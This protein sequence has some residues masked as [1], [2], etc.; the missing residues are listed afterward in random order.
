MKKIIGKAASSGIS[1]AKA[2]VIENQNFKIDRK[3]V[4]DSKQ[5]IMIFN[6]AIKEAEKQIS[7][8]RKQ[9]IEKLGEKKAAIFDAHLAILK[10][11]E[12]EKQVKDLINNE[13]V[14]ASFAV[15]EIGNN[16][17]TIFLSMEDQYMK[18]RA[19]DVEDVT[20]RVIRIIEKIEI[21]DLSLINEPVIIISNDLTPSET[22]QLN[23]KF[24]KGFVIAIG[25]RT[26]HSAI[27]ARSLEIP[28]IVGAGNEIF[29][30]KSRDEVLIDG[31]TGE[32]YVSP[33]Q[34]VKKEFQLKK[35][36]YKHIF[37]SE[38]KF[39]DKET[40]TKDGWKSVVAANIGL[41]DDIY[42]IKKFGAQGVGLFRT[43]FLY[44][45]SQDWPTEEE[46]FEIYKKVLKSSK[47]KIV[48]R[49]LDIGGDKKLPY[50]TFPKE[51]N[52]FLGHRA[53][54]FQLS[55]P[56]VL[57]AQF[58]ALLRASKYGKLAINIPMISTIGEF[59]KVKKNFDHIKNILESEGHK[60]GKYEL[61]IMV[62]VPAT[63]EFI[64]KF[65]KHVDFFSIGTND[66]IQYTFAA[67]RMSKNVSYLYQPFSPII[68]GMIKKVIDASHIEKK[69]TGIC[70]ELASEKLLVPVFVGMGLDEFSVPANLV[71]GIRRVISMVEKK[72]LKDLVKEIL[73][74]ERQE[75]VLTRL[76]KYFKDKNIII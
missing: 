33:T 44:M 30:I 2:H 49:T 62:E 6:D 14:N 52:P 40:I 20:S 1:I 43:E 71:P 75:E 16:F 37:E 25:G 11:P 27:M 18:E 68:L 21:Q 38:K 4:D 56:H 9:S 17:K 48:I 41:I 57:V 26:S 69:W 53:I 35:E 5:E 64:N 63:V 55:M 3:I 45:Y 50:Y 47:D 42:S 58:R 24:V 28:A 60:I 73:N 39:I 36:N 76:K 74:F 46:Q 10:D 7:K 65:S 32:I 8:L 72:D 22:S 15:Q 67:D 51:E 61:G 13:K 54:R 70:G 29:K 19:S 31:S 34:G 23:K 12:L 59:L 66:L